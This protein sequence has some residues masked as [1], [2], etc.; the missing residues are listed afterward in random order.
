MDYYILARIIHILGIVAWIG[1]VAMVSTVII[2]AAR[3]A[4]NAKEGV[5]LMQTVEKNFAPQARITTLLT[6]LSGFYM[7]YAINGW[8]RYAD[9]HF[10]WIHAMTLVWL[11]FTLMLFVIEPLIMHKKME[12]KAQKDPQ[13]VLTFMYR[14]HMAALIASVLTIIGAVAGAH[15]WFFF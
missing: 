2:P 14:L 3:R 15:G 6:G 12:E 5:K 10:W 1:G 13:K 4:K 9:Y 7:L 11:F 8:G